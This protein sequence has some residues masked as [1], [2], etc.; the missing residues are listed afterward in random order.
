MLLR[1]GY[2]ASKEFSVNLR[3]QSYL[4]GTNFRG[5]Y[6]SRFSHK[7]AKICTREMFRFVQ[8]AKINTR[9]IFL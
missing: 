1:G 5:Y 6:F 9:E 7:I 8:T 3:G 4:N 2:L